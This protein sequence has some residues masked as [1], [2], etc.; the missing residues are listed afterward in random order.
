MLPDA[1][2]RNPL[3]M[4][5]IKP[6]RI[7]LVLES[8]GYT[9]SDQLLAAMGSRLQKLIRQAHSPLAEA[10]VFRFEGAAF[11]VLV[12]N[13][14]DHEVLADLGHHLKLG[15]QQ[16]LKVLDREHLF[17]LSIGSA[18]AP[19]HGRDTETLFKNAEV[20]VNRVRTEGGNAFRLFNAEM[21]EKREQAILLERA[22]GQAIERKELALHY[23]PQVDLRQNRIAGVEVLLRWNSA[24]HGMIPPGRFIPLAEEAGL[25]VSIGQWVLHHACLQAKQWEDA[26]L[27]P[28]TLAV[29]ISARQMQHPDFVAMVDQVLRE[30]GLNPA[31]LE[32]EI[33]ESVAMQDVEHTISTLNSLRRLGVNIAIDDFG[34]GFSSLSY[35]QRFPLDK[36]KV[37]QSFV[38]NITQDA[39]IALSVILLARSLQLRVIAEGVETLEQVDALRSYGCEEMQGFFFGRPMPA[40]EFE[41]RLQ[42]VKQLVA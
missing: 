33:T 37:D 10:Q 40:G 23:Q 36:I 24:E 18:M 3:A 1:S 38:R 32:L 9:A 27:S 8:Q 5:L 25:I 11:G 16:P 28:I 15:M 35:L 29:N 41:H 17:T 34:T 26:N 22:L 21:G 12:P 6:D 13:A 39:T 4:L 7:K 14:R 42:Q 2:S 20:V 19:E 31:R 30:T